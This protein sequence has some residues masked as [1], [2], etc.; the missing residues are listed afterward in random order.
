MEKT[1]VEKKILMGIVQLQ[2]PPFR[3]IPIVLPMCFL[4]EKNPQQLQ[5]KTSR[6]QFNVNCPTL[7]TNSVTSHFLNENNTCSKKTSWE[8]SAFIFHFLK[9]FQYCCIRD[10]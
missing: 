5:K 6:E 10:L 3:K 8:F 1:P 7:K 9:T 2:L 4:N